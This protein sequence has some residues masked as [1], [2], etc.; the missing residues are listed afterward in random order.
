MIWFSSNPQKDYPQL[1]RRCLSQSLPITLY[2]VTN[3]RA[4][5]G[6]VCLTQEAEIDQCRANTVASQAM[7]T[8]WAS[9]LYC[10]HTAA[11]KLCN[12]QTTSSV[13]AWRALSNASV[14]FSHALLSTLVQETFGS[15]LM[16]PSPSVSPSPCWSPPPHRLSVH[17]IPSSSLLRHQ[18]CYTM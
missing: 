6:L 2:S 4:S 14:T 1:C 10:A 15:S 5:A 18:H 13:T 11:R 9:A 12:S 7:Q 17:S 3:P 8:L 16:R